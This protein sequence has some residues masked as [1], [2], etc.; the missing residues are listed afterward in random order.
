MAHGSGGL[1]AV[2]DTIRSFAFVSQ[3]AGLK[4]PTGVRGAWSTVRSGVRTLAQAKVKSTPLGA[5]V[6]RRSTECDPGLKKDV[7]QRRD[8]IGVDLDLAKA[9]YP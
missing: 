2:D 1:R 7:L 9:R 5:L 3:T 4:S 6:G 8:R